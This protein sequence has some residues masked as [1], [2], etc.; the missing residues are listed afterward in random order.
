MV[1]NF[2]RA[3]KADPE[4]LSDHADW[5]C[6]EADLH[7]RH[8]W[9]VGQRERLTERLMGDAEFF[10]AKAAGW[11]L[12]GACNWIGS[13]WCSGKGPWVSLDGELVDCRQLPHLAYGPRGIAADAGFGKRREFI[14]EWIAALS[15]RLRDV[16]VACGDWSRVTGPAVLDAGGGLTGVFLDPPYDQ[17]ERAEVYTHESPVAADV[18]QWCV[19]NGGNPKLRIVLA[20]Y[21]GEHNALET[22]GWRAFA[23]KAKGGYGSQGEGR[24]RDNAARE[25]LWLSPH[26]M[27][28]APDL[29]G[30]AA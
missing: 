13:G 20:G 23:W 22:E 26:C 1:A 29:F 16:R 24:G 4:A 28:V 5:P 12:W 8:V 6:N 14:L 3:A 30:A 19:E 17:D 9:L 18:R 27:G 21:D 10:D 15:D 11:W 7:A 2:W 25:R